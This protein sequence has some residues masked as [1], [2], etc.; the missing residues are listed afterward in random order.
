[1]VSFL[2][3]FHRI[4]LALVFCCFRFCIG[5]PLVVPRQIALEYKPNVLSGVLFGYSIVF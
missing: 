2:F 5:Q 4:H 1:M 3:V